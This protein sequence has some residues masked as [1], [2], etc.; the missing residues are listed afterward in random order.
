M[1]HRDFQ[2]SKPD[3][4]VF[5]DQNKCLADRFVKHVPVVAALFHPTSPASIAVIPASCT[6][7]HDRLVT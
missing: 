1:L 6:A 5:G 2:E 7:G 3:R 4:L